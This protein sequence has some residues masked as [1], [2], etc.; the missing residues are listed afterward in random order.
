MLVL[1]LGTSW[2]RERGVD[3]YWSWSMSSETIESAFYS[4]SN[5]NYFRCRPSNPD[6]P[7]RRE[8]INSILLLLHVLLLPRWYLFDGNGLIIIW[9]GWRYDSYWMAM[10]W[11]PFQHRLLID[12]IEMMMVMIEM[13]EDGGS[14][15][16]RM[17]HCICTYPVVK[18]VSD[19]SY[20]V[21]VSGW[22]NWILVYFCSFICHY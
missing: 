22:S 12:V 2:A 7:V 11:I 8:M 10:E 1:L 17:D 13:T 19:F 3:G 14:S 20:L 5:A 15:V 21:L 16:V 6:T 9:E 4:W 18:T